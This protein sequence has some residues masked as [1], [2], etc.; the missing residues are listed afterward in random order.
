MQE[1]IPKLKTHC[2]KLQSNGIIR[3]VTFSEILYLKADDNYTSCLL[4][5]HALYIMCQTLQ[6]FEVILGNQF[7]RC[8]KSYLVNTKYIREINKRNHAV[9]LTTGEKLPFSRKKAKI[10]E[11]KMKLK[12]A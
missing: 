11:E 4:N 10:L 3:F 9:I 6:S 7:Y 5:D 1:L 2:L 8:H 12:T